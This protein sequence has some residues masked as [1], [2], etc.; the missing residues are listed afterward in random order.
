MPGKVK[1][2]FVTGTNT[3]VGKTHVATL[4]ILGLRQRG[5]SVRVR[6][7]VESGCLE[8]NGRWIP[9]DA[10]LL[11]D[12]AGHP[13]PLE[14][15]CPYRFADAIS[16]ERACRLENRQLSL[17]DLVA[18]CHI[19]DGAFLV[20]E[21]AGGF[22]SPIATGCLNADLAKALGLPVVIVADDRL[23]ILN[24]VLLTVE[25]VRNRGLNPF[26]VIIN[27]TDSQVTSATMD[28]AGELR[29]WLQ[30]PV[31]QTLYSNDFEDLSHI[32]PLKPLLE[33]LSLNQEQ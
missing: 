4:L 5:L 21:G 8:E 30:I 31:I 22:Y 32:A 17:E 12:A 26:A 14:Q 10:R 2:C 16:P 18:A 6:K 3:G 27:Q 11:N 33:R 20:V 25:T 15:V 24:H 23:G 28:N 1:G 13:D 9:L 7:P 29:R 19:E